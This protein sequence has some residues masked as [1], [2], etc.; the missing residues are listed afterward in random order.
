M[1][2]NINWSA[3]L[4][5]VPQSDLTV[6]IGTL[7]SHDTSGFFDDIKTQEASEEGIVWPD[8]IDH[9]GSYTVAGVTYAQ[10]IELVNGY[11]V[12]YENTGSFY[13]VNLVNSNN[14]IFDQ[15]AGVYVPHANAMVIPSNSAGLQTVALG[16][17]V[18][19]AT[20]KQALTEQGYT[21][22]RSG[23]LDNADIASSVIDGKVD[24]IHKLEGLDLANPMTVTP[25]SR[26]AG[27]ISQTISGDGET[28]STVTRTA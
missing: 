2:A 3:G 19:L 5:N 28:T 27:T 17:A 21:V 22:G 18:N 10:K 15:Q 16:S 20:V 24:D 7:F 26:N 14:N 6:V 13:T 9:N 4:V 11:T 12:A 8:I 25:T 23:N 1:A